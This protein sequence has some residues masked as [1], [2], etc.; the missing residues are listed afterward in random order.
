MKLSIVYKLSLSS[1]FLV[2]MSAGVVGGIFHVKTTN[3]L[4]ELMGGT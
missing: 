1:I 2:L 3:I 4:I